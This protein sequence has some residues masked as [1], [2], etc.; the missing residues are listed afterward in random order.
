ML[1]SYPFAHHIRLLDDTKFLNH[2][3]VLEHIIVCSITHDCLKTLAY[4]VLPSCDTLAVT[5]DM[6]LR[7]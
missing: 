2:T 4:T 1:E 6:Q 5:C 3:Q 7:Y